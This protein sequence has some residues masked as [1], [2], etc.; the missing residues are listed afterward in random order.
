MSR[1][2]VVCLLTLSSSLILGGVAHGAGRENQ[3]P[4]FF[5]TKESIF[6]GSIQFCWRNRGGVRPSLGDIGILDYYLVRGRSCVVGDFDGNGFLDFAFQGH[7]R[8]DEEQIPTLRVLFYRGSDIIR[9]IDIPGFA[10]LL[11]PATDSEGQ[12]GEPKTDFDGLT[13][14]GE[15][16]TTSVY[17][18]DLTTQTFRE[19]RHASEHH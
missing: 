17:L 18:F 8:S 19:S 9:I 7:K 2:S 10:F 14:S 4:I 6:L 16:G 5:D 11:Y 15:G 1:L 3:S 12:F 13:I